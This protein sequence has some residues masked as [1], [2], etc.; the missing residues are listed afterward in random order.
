MVNVVFLGLYLIGFL[1]WC[2]IGDALIQIQE[3]VSAKRKEERNVRGSF[4]E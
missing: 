2:V 3:R 1:I 4:Q